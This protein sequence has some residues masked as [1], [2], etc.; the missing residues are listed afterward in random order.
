MAETEMKILKIKMEGAKAIKEAVRVLRAGG[1]LI[2]PTDTIYGLCANALD[3]K[4]VEKVFQIKGRRKKKPFSVFVKDMKSA[5][6]IANINESAEK[7]LKNPKITVVL[8]VRNKKIFSEGI[9]K[10][11]KIGIRIPDY[12]FLNK[13]L[14]K[15]SFPLTGTSANISG[16]P[17][18][19]EMENVLQQF[20]G[21]KYQ[22]DLAIDGGAL[23]KSEPSTVIDL[24]NKTPK[25][26]R[27]N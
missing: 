3:E 5:K 9:I 4:A 24:T 21:A 6:Q 18:C 16:K 1:V 26:L 13:L 22:P 15:I 8:P 19:A 23:K 12:K 11:N 7:L 14:K 17:A 10:E 27:G 20:K 25:V 2:C